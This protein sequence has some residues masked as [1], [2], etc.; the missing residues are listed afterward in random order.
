MKIYIPIIPMGAPRPRVTKNGTYNDPRY[1][2][3]KSIIALSAKKIIRKPYPKDTPIGL[4]IDFFFEV[5]KSWSKAKKDSAKWHTLKPDA[6][7][8]SKSVKDALNGIL[9]ADD[10]QVCWMQVRKQYASEFGILI[11]IVPVKQ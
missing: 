7:N 11:E 4:K 5:P 9:Y 10:S 6:D 3:H 1:T 8:L 2:A